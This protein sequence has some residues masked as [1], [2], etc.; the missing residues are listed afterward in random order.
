LLRHTDVSNPHTFSITIMRGA[1]PSARSP[2]MS[3][4]NG[5]NALERLP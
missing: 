3:F 4:M 2:C 1:L 5:Q